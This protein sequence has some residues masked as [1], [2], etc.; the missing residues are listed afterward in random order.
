MVYRLL[1]QNRLLIYDA[2][3]QLRGPNAFGEVTAGILWVRGKVFN[4]TVVR[5]SGGAGGGGLAAVVVLGREAEVTL[6]LIPDNPSSSLWTGSGAR[7]SERR[8]RCLFVECW[9]SLRGWLAIAMQ[10]LKL[11]GLLFLQSRTQDDTSRIAGLG[12]WVTFGV[13]LVSPVMMEFPGV[14][15]DER[16]EQL[17]SQ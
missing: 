14:L 16:G 2:R 6:D 1:V 15:W 12:S 17:V 4:G 7:G 9:H 11:N 8:V 5:R 10:P 3:I 13:G